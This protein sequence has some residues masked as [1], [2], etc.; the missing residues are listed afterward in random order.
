[1]ISATNRDLKSMVK[2]GKFREDLYYRLNVVEIDLPPLR[3]RKGDISVLVFTFLKE[4]CQKNKQMIPEVDPDVMSVLENYKWEGNIRQLKNTV[5]YLLVMSAESRITRDVI[6]SYI[7]GEVDAESN[8]E[9]CDYPLDL[10]EAVRQIE[11]TNIRKALALADGKKAKAAQ[12]LNVPR[13]TLY[14]KMDQYKIEI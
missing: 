7:L 4:F 9:Q 10:N 11:I 12:I 13:T 6:P 2:N 1:M 3:D 14:Y 8:A 5:E